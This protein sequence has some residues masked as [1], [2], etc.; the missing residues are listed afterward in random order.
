MKNLPVG[1]FLFFSI[2]ILGLPG[3][4]FAEEEYQK[5]EPSDDLDFDFEISVQDAFFTEG[6][7]KV[8]IQG[9]EV[10]KFTLNDKEIELN[11]KELLENGFVDTVKFG[12]IKV[13]FDPRFKSTIWLTPSQKKK[14]KDLLSASK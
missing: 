5:V 14:M 8:V 1:V 4:C 12:K 10:T 9:G 11:T 7:K 13:T 3:T 2:T 6:G